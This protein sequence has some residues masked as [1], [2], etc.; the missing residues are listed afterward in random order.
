[1]DR[2][3]SRTEGEKNKEK[4]RGRKI[5]GNSVREVIITKI[6]G[7]RDKERERERQ[8]QKEK[9]EGKCSKNRY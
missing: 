2:E 9:G 4:E 8:R 7:A 1:M 3:K 6:E 5:E